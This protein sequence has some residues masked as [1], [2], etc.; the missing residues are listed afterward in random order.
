[1]VYQSMMYISEYLRSTL[2]DINVPPIWD[3]DSNN[4]YEGEVLLGKGRMRKVKGDQTIEIN[5][6]IVYITF[7]QFHTYLIYKFYSSIIY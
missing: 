3:V 6:N 7:Y 5:Y 4:K 2:L 1:M